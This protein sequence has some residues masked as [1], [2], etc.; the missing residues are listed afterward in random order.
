[1]AKNK[2]KETTVSLAILKA[3][4][5]YKFWRKLAEASGANDFLL[6]YGGKGFVEAAVSGR[7]IYG[8][9]EGGEKA[10][11]YTDNPMGKGFIA[12]KFIIG[13]DKKG[14]VASPSLVGK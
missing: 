12:G 14:I 11:H 13:R 3:G 7:T 5:A 9:W 8:W 1:M 2:I 4:G 6:K 10:W